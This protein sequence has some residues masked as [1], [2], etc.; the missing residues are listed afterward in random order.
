MTESNPPPPSPPLPP[1]PGSK[2]VQVP[3]MSVSN[4]NH[5]P[6]IDPRQGEVVVSPPSGTTSIPTTNGGYN[7][8]SQQNHQ[9]QPPQQP[10]GI[11]RFGPTN[12][13]DQ[14]HD[15]TLCS[16]NE[17]APGNFGIYASLLLIVL[18]MV[19]SVLILNYGNLVTLSEWTT[20]CPVGYESACKSVGGVYRFAF[21]LSCVFFLQLL[22]T[23]IY[24]KFFDYVWPFK[25]ITF[26][27]ILIGFFFAP[28]QVFDLHGFAWFARIAAFLYL[29]SQ[30]VILLDFAYTWNEAWVRWSEEAENEQKQSL[31]LIGLVAVSVFL[32]SG[33]LTVVGIM[34]WQFQGCPDSTAILSLTIVLCVMVTTFQ[35]FISDDGYLL[36]SAI[37]TAYATYICYSAVILNPDTTCNPTLSTGYQTISKAVGIGILILSLTWSTR[38]TVRKIKEA[39]GFDTVVTQV[40]LNHR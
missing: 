8:V 22:G 4:G 28:A 1:P 32:F 35:L 25:Y 11:N 36:T 10:A 15:S 6:P 3:G 24:T 14:I 18:V 21:A 34:F 39:R 30:Q 19:G 7:G 29:V 13:G 40:H 23:A 17:F 27:F 9:I 2:V 26:V 12:H 33:S 37:M 16:A 20:D 38:T 31:W 5:H